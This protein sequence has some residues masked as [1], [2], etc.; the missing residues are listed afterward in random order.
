MN[1]YKFISEIH[2]SG[3]C[4]VSKV[5]KINEE[6]KIYICK[7]LPLNEFRYLN[8]INMFSCLQHPNFLNMK[9]FWF[10]KAKSDFLDIKYS[11]DA[12][13]SDE[14][15]DEDEKYIHIILPLCDC[16]LV[17][18]L[19]KRILNESEKLNLIIKIVKAIDYLHSKG[20]YHGDIKPENILMSGDEPILTDFGLSDII[21]SALSGFF[22]ST[23][24]SC[25]PQCIETK[26]KSLGRK[27]TLEDSVDDY[28][29]FY[30]IP[31]PVQNDI[32]SLGNVIYY[33][34]MNG[35]TSL[36]PLTKKRPEY[37]DIWNDYIYFINNYSTIKCTNDFDDIFQEMIKPSQ[38][39]RLT[40][41]SKVTKYFQCEREESN[42]ILTKKEVFSSLKKRC[43][44]IRIPL[45]KKEMILHYLG[46][47]TRQIFN[48]DPEE[49]SFF[50]KEGD[51]EIEEDLIQIIYSL[52]GKILEIV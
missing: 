39:D 13:D 5:E 16:N 19:N 12:K 43:R 47:L 32:F 40:D 7:M 8:E 44:N 42:I 38:K 49:Y 51:K 34:F 24:Y 31:N 52:K 46:F 29:V 9:E 20:L 3:R 27:L 11:D 35:K 22:V 37:E 21:D 50:N 33:I 41:L 2:R 30:E 23:S 26:P 36:I 4:S 15:E 1:N 17:E 10:E 45:K 28:P 48:E 6:N 25:S 14:D 18:Y